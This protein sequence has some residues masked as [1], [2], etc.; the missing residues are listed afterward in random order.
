M[1]S[2]GAPASPNSCQLRRRALLRSSPDSIRRVSPFFL[3][4]IRPLYWRIR[5]S[6]VAGNGNGNADGRSWMEPEKGSAESFS[7]WSESGSGSRKER[8]GRLG[9]IAAAGAAGVILTAGLALA[10]LSLGK[11]SSA[12]MKAQMKPLTSQQEAILLSENRDEVDQ[13]AK[14]CNSVTLDENDELTGKSLSGSECDTG[15]TKDSFPCEE[16]TEASSESGYDVTSTQ[17]VEYDNS[18]SDVV[19]L[20]DVAATSHEVEKQVQLPTDVGEFSFLPDS[21]PSAPDLSAIVNDECPEPSS[22]KTMTSDESP[23][24]VDTDT[25]QGKVGT[26]MSKENI[27]SIHPD[28]FPVPDSNQASSQEKFDVMEKIEHSNL[29]FN[30]PGPSDNELC[31][32]TLPSESSSVGSV[33]E[34]SSLESNIVLS[35]P[36]SSEQI[37]FELNDSTPRFPVNDVNATVTALE[38]ETANSLGSLHGNVPYPNGVSETDRSSSFGVSPSPENTF[39]YAGIPAPSLVSAALQVTPGK[40]VVPP[41]I[42]QVQGQAL[43]ALQVLKVIDSDVR[44]GDLCTRREY[45]RWL[46]A[47]SSAL[48]RNSIS[49]VYPAMYIEN[50]TD[51][52]FDDVTP[53]D[54]DFTSIQGLAEAGLISSKLSSEGEQDNFFFS[55]DSPLSRQDLVS[56][57]MAIEKRQLPEV[58]KK[59]L[60]QQSGFI[61]IDRI[62]PHAWPALMA[63][64]SAGEHGI[65]ALAFGYTR[66]FQPDKPVTKAQAAI[67]LA[68]GD[69]T[70]VVG[71]ELA[72]IEAESLADTA[73][74]AH[75]ALVAQVEKDLHAVFEKQLA[76]EREKIAAV[77]KL[78]EEA[79]LELEKIKAERN[80]GNSLLLK[81][82]AAIESEMEVLSKLRLDVEEQ[83]QSLMSDRIKA[84][85]EHDR[86]NKLRKEAEDESQAIIKLQYELEVERKALSMA[87]AWAED[88]A[89]R[90]REH[91]KALEEAR[92][93]WEQ[94]GI[95]VIVDS[96]LQDDAATELTWLNADA[97][98]LSVGQSPVKE[99]ISR[100]ENLV[101]KLEVM[102]SEVKGKSFAAIKRIIEKIKFIIEHFKVQAAEAANKAREVKAAAVS[103]LKSSAEDL[104]QKTESSVV[105]FSST[106]KDGMKRL[107]EE[108]KEGMDRISQKFKM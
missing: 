27:G 97:E 93:R 107:T 7:G 4:N 36:T 43:A 45:A 32:G 77:E 35:M 71:E 28:I 83:L 47:A 2:L 76:M 99:T 5:A 85:I 80:E 18:K 63:D 12:G 29:H 21:N 108:C 62:S 16:C 14:K 89:K 40:V 24:V 100:G 46:V 42:D 53:Q 48:S 8:Q 38:V 96:E 106:V 64:I 34:S 78:A 86:L 58:D 82:R 69:A 25:S 73:V 39:S 31:E 17:T 90:T 81:G 11:K 84:S 95:K 70:E 59:T 22:L 56:W 23:D 72:R 3:R 74:A 51:L 101:K 65:T 1:A 60:Y 19:G 92:Y 66:L 87:R 49:K 61:D 57:K 13:A 54:P 6:S 37:T 52:A 10:S 94:R 91:A 26:D 41:T 44:P 9:G 102:A 103:T 105:S 33:Y 15:T 98:K 104:S 79:T 50:V 55:P 20:N 88:E 75:S 30:V 68:V 67:A